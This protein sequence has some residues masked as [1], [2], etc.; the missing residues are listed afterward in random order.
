VD[1]VLLRGNIDIRDIHLVGNAPSDFIVCGLPITWGSRDLANSKRS[2]LALTRRGYG[3]R[4]LIPSI[5]NGPN[6]DITTIRTSVRFARIKQRSTR[7]EE[8]QMRNKLVALF[9]LA[10][11]VLGG[12][13]IVSPK[14]TTAANES[15]FGVDIAGLTRNATGLPEEQFAAH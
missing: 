5:P 12:V 1:L 4:C 11:L 13:F 3:A 9:G 8:S 14:A 6:I 7:N 10:A 2:P 15:A